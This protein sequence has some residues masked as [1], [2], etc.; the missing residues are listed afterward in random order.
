MGLLF[1]SLQHLLVTEL[2]GVKR[3]SQNET[4]FTEFEE[5][6]FL[7]ILGGLNANLPLRQ[8]CGSPRFGFSPFGITRM[9]E[10]LQILELVQF[11]GLCNLLEGVQSLLTTGKAFGL[12]MQELFIQGLFFPFYLFIDRSLAR[13]AAR[14][15]NDQPALGNSNGSQRDLHRFIRGP[16]VETL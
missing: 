16:K 6:C 4:G 8:G 2:T 15:M 7:R 14:W 11:P 13:S 10:H 1:I 9:F 12:Q 3:S 5:L